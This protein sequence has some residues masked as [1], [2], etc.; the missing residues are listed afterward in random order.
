MDIT[1]IQ[2]VVDLQ[3]DLTAQN[4]KVANTDFSETLQKA[5]AEQNTDELKESCKEIE[6]YMLSYVFKKMKDSMLTGEGITEK[7]DYEE[8]FEDSMIEA[9]C[10][11]MVEAGG[12]GL[13]DSMYKQM[14]STY[15]AQN[16]LANEQAMHTSSVD[17]EI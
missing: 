8:M 12:I 10:E 15:Q 7:S 6:S 9:M 11:N 16:N 2:S 5:M 14:L 17:Q 13:A 3:K 4:N 1:S